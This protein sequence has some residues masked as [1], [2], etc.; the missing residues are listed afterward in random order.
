MPAHSP[1]SRAFTSDIQTKQVITARATE[2]RGK[3][4][5]GSPGLTSL[6]IYKRESQAN[7]QTDVTGNRRQMERE[8]GNTTWNQDRTRTDTG[9]L[10]RTDTT[11][12]NSKELW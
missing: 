5:E 6:Y 4:R 9:Q 8:E 2:V 11:T 7:I 10:N 1:G 12:L 3:N